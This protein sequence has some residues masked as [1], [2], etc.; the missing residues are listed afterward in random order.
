M[1][2]NDAA[3]GELSFTEAPESV[4]K[5]AAPRGWDYAPAPETVKA[6]LAAR[7]DLFINGSWTAPSKDKGVEPY[8]ETI[9]PATEA[10]LCRVAPASA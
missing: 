4:S 8:F 7:Y 10:P 9:N 2:S 1:T 6:P 5:P 3:T